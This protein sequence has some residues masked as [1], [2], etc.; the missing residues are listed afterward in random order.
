MPR[1]Q[2]LLHSE[3]HHEHGFWQ[4]EQ[5]TMSGDAYNTPRVALCA[6][7]SS[8]AVQS[9]RHKHQPH[10]LKIRHTSSILTASGKTGTVIFID[11]CNRSRNSRARHPAFLES[12]GRTLSCN[13]LVCGN[14]E[15]PIDCCLCLLSSPL[16]HTHVLVRHRVGPCA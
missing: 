8:E 11:W 15:R 5:V 2:S 1:V 10:R 12:S 4:V 7:G 9:S 14:N 16:L 13:L 6:L 3:L